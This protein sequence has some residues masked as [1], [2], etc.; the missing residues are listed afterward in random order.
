M[1]SKL[2]MF[3]GKEIRRVW[4]EKK[5]KW[6]FSVVDIVSALINQPNFTI[7]FV[8]MISAHFYV[9][10]LLPLMPFHNQILSNMPLTQRFQV[11]WFAHC[12]LNLKQVFLKPVE[13]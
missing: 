7:P 8:W 5:E 4:D 3:N 10:I 12:H 11:L 2:A 13:G 9:L 6:Y 1:N